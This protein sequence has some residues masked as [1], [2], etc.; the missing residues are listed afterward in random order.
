MREAV[1]WVTGEPAILVAQCD[2]QD[3]KAASGTMQIPKGRLE[4]PASVKYA[5]LVILEDYSFSILLF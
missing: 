1:H 3:T 5:G 2:E 4:I